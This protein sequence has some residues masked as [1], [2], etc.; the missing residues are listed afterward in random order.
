MRAESESVASAFDLSYH[1]LTPDQQLLFRRLGLH[2]GSDF[3]AYIG[4]ALSGLDLG[5]TQRLLDDLYLHHLIEEPTR[6]RYRMHDLIREQA[7]ALAAQDST[8][9]NEAAID[10]LLSYFLHTA[11]NAAAHIAGRTPVPA[12]PP[13]EHPPV[14]TPD[15]PTSAESLAWLR[16]ERT[17]LDSAVDRAVSRTIPPVA[18]HLPIVL[19]QFLRGQG[20]W[21]QAI[22]LNRSAE[23]VARK[24]ND[25]AGEALAL[26]SRSSIHRVSGEYPTAIACLERA[27]TLHRG[28]GNR[29]GEANDLYELGVLQR[30]ACDYAADAAT[31]TEARRIYR[32]LGN[33]L[34]EANTFHEMGIAKWLAGDLSGSLESQSHARDLYRESHNDI[35]LAAAYGEI[36]LVNNSAGNYAVAATNVASSLSLNQEME[37]GTPRLTRSCLSERRNI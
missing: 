28:L 11:I 2:S 36:A 20:Y 30:L 18:I 32:E 35:G 22:A 12:P 37:T 14:W 10:R 6:G 1:D 9:D 26:W 16:A 4:A 8:A 13:V 34:G 25:R 17:N 31:Q 29:L 23:A 24:V 3:D 15:F 21:E 19:T 7:R 5:P 33:N 27:I